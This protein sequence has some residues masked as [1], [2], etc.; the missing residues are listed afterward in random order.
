[1]ISVKHHI[2]PSVAIPDSTTKLTALQSI[3]QFHLQEGHAFSLWRRPSDHE[4]HLLVCTTGINHLDEINVEDSPCGFVFAPFNKDKKKI[5]LKADH[6]YSFN[7][8]KIQTHEAPDIITRPDQSWDKPKTQKLK[9][10]YAPGKVTASADAVTFKSLV[11]KS[12][13]GV[14]AGQFEKVVPS[15]TKQISLPS[16]FDPLLIFEKL[17]EQ[18]PHALVTLV[19]SPETGTWIGATPELLV[20][21]DDKM[22]FKTTAV[23]GTQRLQPGVNL[24]AI[25]WTQKEIE[26]QALV[27][28]YIINCFKRIR[29]REFDEQGP[30]TTIAGNIIH[31]R[32]D[33]EVD[34][35]ATNFPQ[36][37]TV[38]LKLLHPTS[39]VCGMPLD[40][41]SAFLLEN[42]GYDREFYSGYLGPVNFREESHIY[43]NLRCMSI[44]YDTAFLYAGAGVTADSDPQMEWDETEMKMNTLLE[45][46]G[47]KS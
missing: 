13:E 18:Y 43:V 3:L 8:G 14:L 29:L 24:K 6:L 15:R 10:H 27:C 28:R 26:E 2:M 31:L 4:K 39:A 22:R 17:C 42:E 38:M 32:T 47:V 37:G 23:A 34:M 44:Q 46:I 40:A 5:F 35:R 19:S 25:A 20:S 1:M 9:Y 21:V 16:H 11:K 12:I 7:N 45:V 36:L 41:A 33:Y 30:K